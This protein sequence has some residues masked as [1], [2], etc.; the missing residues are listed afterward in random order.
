MMPGR[1]ELL[2]HMPVFGALREDTLQFLLQRSRRVEVAAGACFFNEGEV[3]DS[4]F[5]LESGRV[6]VLKRWRGSDH[7]LHELQAGDCFGEMALMDL[8]PRSATVCALEDCRALEFG[9]TELLQLFERDAEQFAL[10]QMNLGREVCRR[11]RAA[12]EL[13]ALHWPGDTPPGT[14]V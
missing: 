4:M 2:Q 9:A 14:A 5:V 6:A 1:I 11:L 8:G 3:G 10:I 7:L 12:S 13:L